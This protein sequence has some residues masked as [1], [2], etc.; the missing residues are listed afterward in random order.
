MTHAEIVLASHSRAGGAGG[1]APD[2]SALRASD[3]AGPKPPALTS[4][5]WA[6]RGFLAERLG[7]THDARTAYRVAVT[8]GFSLSA[9]TALLRLEAAAGAIS[10]ALM[11]AQQLLLWHET[12]AAAVLGAATDGGATA[13]LLPR[14]PYFVQWFVAELGAGQGLDAVRRSL[15]EESETPPHVLLGKELDEWVKVE[16]RDAAAGAQRQ[17]QRVSA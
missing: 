4:A 7:H 2:T 1:A 15:S 5:D 8:L 12:R 9:Y 16:E 6:R 13:S 14:A 3:A 10:D 11:S 17:Q